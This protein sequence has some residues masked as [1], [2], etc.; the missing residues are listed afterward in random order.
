MLKSEIWISICLFDSPCRQTS[1][2]KFSWKKNVL[3]PTIKP[4]VDVTEATSCADHFKQCEAT[5]KKLD[6]YV[7]EQLNDD[8]D[9][10][11]DDYSACGTDDDDEWSVCW[12]CVNILI[13]SWIDGSGLIIFFQ[14][15]QKKLINKTN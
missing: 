10:D 15:R 9:H 2:T 8:H 11:E 13:S 7:E 6:S 14:W 1:I 4:L 12:F 3:W 5:F